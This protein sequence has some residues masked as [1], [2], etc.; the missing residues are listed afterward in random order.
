MRKIELPEDYAIVLQQVNETGEE[1]LTTLSETLQYDR[2]KLAHILQS[3]R[4]KG[5]VYFSQ[6][7]YREP[8]IKLSSKGRRLMTY[9]W[10]EIGMAAS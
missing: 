8:L 7:T 2:P 9:M 6:D 3:L 4:Q 10:P 1:D 5:L